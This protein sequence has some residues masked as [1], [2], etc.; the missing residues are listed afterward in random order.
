MAFLQYHNVAIRGLSACVPSNVE[1]NRE[2]PLYAPGEAEDVIKAIG[3]ERRHVCTPD[4]AVSDLMV[5]SAE[6]LIR[7]LSWE[8]ESVDLLVVVTQT[9]D[10]I[11]HPTSFVIH[12]RLGLSENT[13]CLD[14]FHGCP[15]WVAGL[16]AVLPMLQT[17]NFKRAIYI[18]GDTISKDQDALS[19]ED[20]PLFGDAVTATALEFSENSSSIFL[21]TG[22]RSYDGASL[23]KPL[24]GWKNPFSPE[25]L[26]QKQ[27][28]LAG[29]TPPDNSD[30][31]DPMDVFSFAITTVPKSIKKLCSKWDIAIDSIDK[32][33]L[34][35][36]NKMIVGMI[37]KRLGVPTEKVPTSLRDYGNTTCA[38]IP[39]TMVTACREDYSQ[40]KQRTIVCGFGQG[41][42]WGSAYFETENLVIPEVVV[43]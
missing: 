19:R 35:Q 8:R 7:E 10:Y 4:I 9:P 31:R 39:L 41:L 11:N 30:L 15:G 6:V 1:E 21:N 27:D 13:L 40:G 2:L 24:G 5:K 26:K 28:R 36:A 12:E 23:I 42:S 32:L 18:G 37:A 25:T 43:L 3:I 16:S 22:T 33:I 29:L 14:F 17:G 34:H 38:S 20:K